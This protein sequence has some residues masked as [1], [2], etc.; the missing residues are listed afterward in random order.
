MLYRFDLNLKYSGDAMRREIYRAFNEEISRY[1]NALAYY[2]QKNEWE[3]FKAKA[4]KLFDYCEK[5]E[6][7]EIERRFTRVFWII[8]AFVISGLFLMIRIEPGTLPEFQN[9]KKLLFFA[10]FAASCFDLYFYLNFR[11]YMN[12]KIVYYKK[13]KEHFIAAIEQDFR[14]DVHVNRPVRQSV[15]NQKVEMADRDIDAF[16][17]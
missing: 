6:A 5:V 7:S 4:G 10:T 16:S 9:L 15:S 1:R 14:K 3:T 12:Q 11:V 13:R 2:A 8:I 17:A